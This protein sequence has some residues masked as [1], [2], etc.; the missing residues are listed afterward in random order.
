[1][2]NGIAKLSTVIESAGGV[3]AFATQVLPSILEGDKDNGF[4]PRM[5]PE[6]FSLLEIAE[7][8][9]VDPRGEVSEAVNTT[10]FN[11]IINTLLSK[12]VLSAYTEE[13]G[14][15]DQLTT[16]FN[17]S[18]KVD[19]IPGAFLEGDLEDIPEGGPYPHTANIQDKYVELGWNKRG[20]ILD[21][22]KEAIK[23]D[24]TGMILEKARR[25]G[26]MAKVKHEQII[27]EA[28]LENAST[29][30]YASWRPAGNPTTLYDNSSNDPF[31]SGTLDN[32]STNTLA[33]ET[34]ID[35]AMQL[36]GAMT[37]EQGLP[38]HITPKIL[39]TGV[40]YRGIAASITQ[41]GQNI[42][43][44]A[45]PGIKNIYSGAIMPLASAHV[46]NIVGTKYWL[47]GDF[48][49]Q[50]V[51]TEVFPLQT[52]QAKAGNEQEFERDVMFRYKARLM[53]GCGALT[54]RYVIF[55]TGAS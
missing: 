36:W 48:K 46:D 27:M 40:G 52:M 11:V 45:P 37:D 43:K 50:F 10:Q 49:K 24:Q 16:P 34:D 39:L 2:L 55:S 13:P 8:T 47:I 41:S 1:M 18:L 38:L 42:T 51:Y 19:T 7:A 5:A 22:T 21:I 23:F 20:L 54:N 15:I 9:G 28:V 6:D 14:I 31:S 53:G 4:K 44:T 25:L 32:Y 29:G 26:E 35:E 30:D 17:S 3:Q 33:D 12:K